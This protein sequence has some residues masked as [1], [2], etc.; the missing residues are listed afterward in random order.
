MGGGGGGALLRGVGQQ[1]GKVK[2]LTGSGLGVKGLGWGWTLGVGVQLV[3]GQGWPSTTVHTWFQP[4]VND[5]CI[6]TSNIVKCVCLSLYLFC[7]I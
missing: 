6:A 7:F 3:R 2:D 4:P 5:F 1:L